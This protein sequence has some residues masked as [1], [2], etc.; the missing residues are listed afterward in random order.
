LGGAAAARARAAADDAHGPPS[1]R[2]MVTEMTFPGLRAAL[3]ARSPGADT[4][5]RFRD[6]RQTAANNIDRRLLLVHLLRVR[7]A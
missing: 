4:K 3:G 6:R 7:P 2:A 1:K 5:P